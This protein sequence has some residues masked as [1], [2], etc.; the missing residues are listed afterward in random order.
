MI[1]KRKITTTILAAFCICAAAQTA[2]EYRRLYEK[3]ASRVGYA[4]VGIETLIDNWAKADSSG[5]PDLQVARFRFHFEKSRRDSITVRE[6]SRHLGM[7]PILSLKD[8]TGKTVNYYKETFYDAGEFNVAISELDIA[9][10]SDERRL[11]LRVLM[12][13]ALIQYDKEGTAL[14]LPYL[15]RLIEE[16]YVLKRKWTLPG[17]EYTADTFPD[18]V[19]SWCHAFYSK[20][21]PQGYEAFKTLSDK[22]LKYEKN[23][24]SFIDNLGAYNLVVKKNDKAALNYYRKA[25]KIDPDDQI[26]IRN[27]KLIERRTAK[28]K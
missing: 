1:M 20:G 22:M 26:A 21:T 6:E 16:N 8:S 2:D 19:Q 23:G 25:L 12:A 11:D 9:A 10:A 7:E 5:S 28:K 15:T 24:V 3:T 17:E 4:G 27:I 13:D 14:S 18:L